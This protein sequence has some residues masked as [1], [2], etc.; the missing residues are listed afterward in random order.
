MAK[1]SQLEIIPKIEKAANEKKSRFLVILVLGLTVLPSLT[2]WLITGFKVGRIKLTNPFAQVD[3]PK[4]RM[5]NLPTVGQEAGLNQ[6]ANSNLTSLPGVW[7]VKVISLDKDFS[8]G[9]NSQ[10]VLQAASLIKLPIVAS[11]YHQVESA[12]FDLD[13]IYVLAESDKRPGAGVLQ[14]QEVG[15]ELKLGE[16]ASLALSQS[17]N[18]AANILRNLVGDAEINRLI[19][20]WGMEQTSLAQ[21]LTSADD[22]GLFFKKLYEGSILNQEHSRRMLND[23]TDTAFEDRIP[24]GVPEGIEVAHKVGSEERV[25]SDAGIVFTPNSPFVLVIMSDQTDVSLAVQKFPKLVEDIY[26]L[27][28]SD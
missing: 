3:M 6:W 23:L 7:A 14:Y 4:V 15:T 13:D 26:W 27:V 9:F 2:F 20:L 18:T 24:A 12:I 8:W 17:D 19:D 1:S 5:I 16:L 22:I 25:V 21:N 10:E 11:F 28:I